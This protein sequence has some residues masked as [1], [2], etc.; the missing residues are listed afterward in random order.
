MLIER[1]VAPALVLL[2]GVLVVPE[3]LATLRDL[4]AQPS[5]AALVAGNLLAGVGLF[6]SSLV[7]V[8]PAQ[9]PLWRGFVLLVLCSLAVL[10]VSATAWA[11]FAIGSMKAILPAL[12]APTPLLGLG[13]GLWRIRREMA[14]AGKTSP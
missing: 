3:A 4:S 8:D 13:A 10:L 14:D 12:A 6:M 7:F 5:I 9:R 11:A 1:Q 2:G